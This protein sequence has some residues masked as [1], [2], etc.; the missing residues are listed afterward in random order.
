MTTSMVSWCSSNH[1]Q[2]HQ[3]LNILSHGNKFA[4]IEHFVAELYY[5]RYTT[6]MFTKQ[7]RWSILEHLI[8]GLQKT[9][10]GNLVPIINTMS[11]LYI[12]KHKLC[13]SVNHIRQLFVI[14]YNHGILGT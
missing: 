8:A 11:I 9:M 1:T 4:I 7:S 10:S 12:S 3:I 6:V 5:F 14:T 13:L 2:F